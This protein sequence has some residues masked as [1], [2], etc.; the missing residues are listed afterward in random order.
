MAVDV[1]D[2]LVS[3]VLEGHGLLLYRALGVV[4]GHVPHQI[5]FVSKV[6]VAFNTL[7]S[8]FLE[9]KDKEILKI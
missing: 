5:P 3:A 6:P 1:L 9:M 2:L 8:F 7:V 4:E